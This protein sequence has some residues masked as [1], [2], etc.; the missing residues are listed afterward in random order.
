MSIEDIALFPNP[1]SPD[2]GCFVRRKHGL[3]VETGAENIHVELNPSIDFHPAY[4]QLYFRV[5]CGE[6]AYYQRCFVYMTSDLSIPP[7]VLASFPPDWV[8]GGEYTP[9]PSDWQRYPTQS[10]ERFY[11][12]V[13]QHRNP[14]ESTWAPDALVGHSYDIYE[15]GTLSTI[16]HDDTGGDRDLDDFVLEA[17][18]VGR[19]SWKA[20]AQAPDQEVVTERV[21]RDGFPGVRPRLPSTE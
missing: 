3:E 8:L 20:I 14:S 21:A 16:Y 7:P 2:L 19:S 1:S 13:G 6:A 18:V 4:H 17:A 15:N 9:R 11:F 5:I 10:G 12:F